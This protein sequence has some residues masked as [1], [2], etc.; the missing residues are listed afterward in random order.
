MRFWAKTT[1]G[2]TLLQSKGISGDKTWFGKKETYQEHI[3]NLSRT[4]QELF[5]RWNLCFSPFIPFLR[6]THQELFIWFLEQ[7]ALPLLITISISWEE[8][9]REDFHFVMSI[10]QSKRIPPMGF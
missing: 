10:Q 1:L 3:N 5:F 7:K 4:Y 6:T 2:D 8:R 9:K